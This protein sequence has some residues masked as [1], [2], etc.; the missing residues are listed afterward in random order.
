MNTQD[1]INE[2]N[3]LEIWNPVVEAAGIAFVNA[4]D[5]VGPCDLAKVTEEYAE[6]FIGTIKGMLCDPA[7]YDLSEEVIVWFN[8]RGIKG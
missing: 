5:T 3:T 1:L 7:S 2:I 6:C 8:V 4:G